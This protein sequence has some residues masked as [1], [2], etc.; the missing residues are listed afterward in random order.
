[1]KNLVLCALTV[2]LA[3]AASPVV[4]QSAASAPMRVGV[5]VESPD[6]TFDTSYDHC[7]AERHGELLRAI[8][9]ERAQPGRRACPPKKLHVVAGL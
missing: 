5:E 8:G 6:A 1:M 3:I 9:R 7:V 2:V 4:V